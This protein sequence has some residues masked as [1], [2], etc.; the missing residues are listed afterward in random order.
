MNDK[1]STYV[2]N[3]INLKNFTFWDQINPKN[4]IEKNF[5]K[6]TLNS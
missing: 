1:K 3:S 4:M 2:P 5:E 6:V